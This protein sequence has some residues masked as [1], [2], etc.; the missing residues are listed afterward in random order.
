MTLD[1]NEAIEATLERA[2]ASFTSVGT[3]PALLSEADAQLSAKL[4]GIVDKAGGPEARFSEANALLM[5]KQIQLVQEYTNKRLLGLTHAQAKLA[6]AQSVKDTS[7]LAGMLEKR[8]TGIAKPLALDVQAMQDRVVR[9]TGASLLQQHKTSVNRYGAAMI[10]DF[11]RQL[12]LGILQGLSNHD[13]VSRLVSVGQLGGVNAKKLHAK[14][15]AY[16]PKPTS[17]TARRYWAERIVRTEKAY[18]Y[19]AAALQSMHTIRDTD[20]PDVQKKILA[21]FD[22]R[23]AEDSIAVH[24]QVRKLEELFRDGAGRMYLHPPARPNDRETVVPWRPHWADT[25]ATKSHDPHEPKPAP[26]PQ[27]VIEANPNTI[28]GDVLAANAKLKAKK[29]A[30]TLAENRQ[31][32][33]QAGSAKAVAAAKALEQKAK[34]DLAAQQAKLQAELQAAQAKA[35]AAAK[36]RATAAFLAGEKAKAQAERV[37]AWKEFEAK[38]KAKAKAEAEQI[39]AEAKAAA[40]AKL[41]AAA[42]EREEKRKAALANKGKPKPKVQ[43]PVAVAPVGDVAKTLIHG[44]VIETKKLS[45]A[46]VNASQ[47]V[48]VRTPDG[49]QAQGVWK[50]AAGEERGLRDGV[51]AGTYYRREVAVAELDR[52]LGG[53]T[54]VPTTVA[55]SITKDG[56]TQVGSVQAF[57]DGA[58]IRTEKFTPAERKTIEGPGKWTNPDIRRVL[59]L[60]TITAN[61]DRHTGNL[62]FARQTMADG[63]TRVRPVAIDNGLAM[64]KDQPCRFLAAGEW[65]RAPTTE[66]TWDFSDQRELLDR[67]DLKKVASMLSEAGID[68]ASALGTLTRINALKINP[69]VLQKAI[70]D[71]GG[72]VERTLTWWCGDRTNNGPAVEAMK[73]LEWDK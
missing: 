7:A 73:G 63:S 28:W 24:G 49:K 15:P 50:P 52:M 39:R 13:I 42:K 65:A 37:R 19:N 64:P 68:K 36:K 51:K 16:F 2:G 44:E 14:D 43:K 56:K 4:H 40:K 45:D 33:I 20:F 17:Y 55:R 48:T 62:M 67:L 69:T 30:V 31:A 70:D 26:P 8:F 29:E 18:A 61:D 34:A 47:L 23:T 3:L 59:L 46:G 12:R 57:V 66:R 35:A 21:H 32:E 60:D 54:I 27:N 1:A 11:E 5:R 71:E 22:N 72:R 38:K 25:E 9:G 41:E 58:T 6:I 10:G 53:D